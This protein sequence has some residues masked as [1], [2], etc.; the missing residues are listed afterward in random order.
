VI[1]THGTPAS[2][3]ALCSTVSEKYM[4]LLCSIENIPMESFAGV[5]VVVLVRWH[6]A[7]LTRHRGG[8]RLACL[9]DSA[10]TRWMLGSISNRRRDI[11]G[12]S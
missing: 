6:R 12:L 3:T 7:D 11:R 8:G 10:P 1:S 4:A 9:C 2:T 5:V